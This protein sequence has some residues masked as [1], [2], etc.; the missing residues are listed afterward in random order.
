MSEE[1][2][3]GERKEA[4]SERERTNP[5][6][7]KREGG[8]RRERRERRGEEPEATAALGPEPPSAQCPGHASYQ[9]RHRP[10][11]PRS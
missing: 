9:D 2:R 6:S 8:G 5:E 11:G 4:N 7:E 1:E 10:P 3:Q